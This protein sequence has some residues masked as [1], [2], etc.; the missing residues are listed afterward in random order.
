M[1]EA[2][3]SVGV[4]LA[5]A[6]A[7]ASFNSI[8]ITGRPDLLMEIKDVLT[9]GPPIFIISC[10]DENISVLTALYLFLCVLFV[11]TVSCT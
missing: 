9:V 4:L 6:L 11:R 3:A 8:R 10:L 2:S 1:T 5:T 7:I